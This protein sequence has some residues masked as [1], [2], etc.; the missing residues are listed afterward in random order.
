MGRLELKDLKYFTEVAK[1]GGF[2]T[3]ASNTYISQPTL[4]KSIKKMELELNVQLFDRTT[5]TLKLTDAGRIVLDQAIKIIS[6][7]NDIHILIDDL[8]NEPSGVIKIGVPPLIGTLFF[9]SIA[10][11]FG[12]RYPNVS[13]ELV[14]LGAKRIEHLVNDRQIDLGIVVQPVEG[15]FDFYP[16]KLEEFMLY[17]HVQHPLAEKSSTSLRELRDESFILFNKEFALHYLIIRKCQEVGFHPKVTYES[18]QWDL[19]TELVK[20][21]IGIT[22]L[23]RSIYSKMDKECVKVTPLVDS[24]IWELVIITKKGS[25]QS[26]AVRELIDSIRE[27][28]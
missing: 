7:V 22:L 16:F 14:E 19:I 2:T 28:K 6:S 23:P 15:D 10:K 18:S 11:T 12:L 24:P 13:L 17:T 20:E 3:A 21:G 5:R 27:K 4:S 8:I 9:P 25:Y 26:F 1:Y